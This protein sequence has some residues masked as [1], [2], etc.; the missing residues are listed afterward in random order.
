MKK[1]RRRLNLP[2][3]ALENRRLL[4]AHNVDTSFGEDGF[5]TNGFVGGFNNAHGVAVQKDGKVIVVGQAHVGDI[6]SIYGMAAVRYNSDGTLDD[7]GPNDSTPDDHF[8]TDG[9][10]TYGEGTSSQANAI[11]IQKDGKILLAGTANVSTP[12]AQQYWL[13][14]RLN[15]DGTPDTDFGNNGIATFQ[16]SIFNTPLNAIT[17]QSDGKILAVGS[18]DNEFLIARITSTG[19]FDSQFAGGN[20]TL[21]WGGVNS[22]TGV[23]VD[24]LGR[25]IVAGGVEG[26]GV[27][28]NVGVARYL[29]NGTLDSTF[30]VQGRTT[31]PASQEGTSVEVNNVVL[32]SDQEIRVSASIFTG[33]FWAGFAFDF[34]RDGDYSGFGANHHFQFN[35]IALLPDDSLIHAGVGFGDNDLNSDLVALIKGED[36]SPFI[37]DADASEGNA[38]ALAP[39]GSIYVA[40]VVDFSGHRDFIL[41]KYE[42]FDLSAWGT[43]TGNVYRDTDGDRVRDTNETGRANVR[44][45]IDLNEDGKWTSGGVTPDPFVFTDNSGNFTF[46]GIDPGAYKIGVVAPSSTTQSNPS[47]K[48]IAVTVVGGKT[49]KGLVFSHKPIAASTQTSIVGSVFND[50]NGNAQRDIG[51]TPEPDL[52][53]IVV[54]I[55]ANKNG[56]LDTKELKTKTDV[57]GNYILKP[58][59]TGTF[60]VTIV[61]PDGWINTTPAFKDARVTTG[62]ATTARFGLAFNDVNDTIDEA[63][64]ATALVINKSVKGTIKNAVDVN[65][66]RLTVT[67]GQTIGFDLDHA[68]SSS[69][70]SYLRLFDSK[71]KLLAS[72]DD[73]AA[74]GEGV[75]VDSYIQHQFTKAGTYYIAISDRLNKAFSPLTG[76]GDRG[77]GTKGKYSLGVKSL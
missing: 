4:A 56:L 11:A 26:N 30:G 6:N 54:F 2:I 52:A 34:K 22:A 19:E 73:G 64:L 47:S 3:E 24:V 12:I 35:A 15:V 14:A 16:F 40:G 48:T 76:N 62:N 20:V 17:L 39:D 41:V 42:G 37:D 72:N 21:D 70:N 13:L 27:D 33:S 77:G 36:R 59:K 61:I 50:W 23:A 71:G 74:L 75:S 68:T 49:V 9:V 29:S 38:I 66:Y 46:T 7:G 8:G 58:T 1:P 51:T 28:Q 53:D 25:I 43:I 18:L 5:V 57:S 60:R 69:L 63:K 55:D 45:Y 32:T 67:A 31:A 10:F 65:L 44:A